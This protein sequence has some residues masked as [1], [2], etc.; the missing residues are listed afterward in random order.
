MSIAHTIVWKLT[1]DARAWFNGD[2]GDFYSKGLSVPVWVCV[3]AIKNGANQRIAI[4]RF[5]P[6][7]GLNALRQS[8]VLA[9]GIQLISALLFIGATRKSFKL[10]ITSKYFLIRFLANPSTGKRA[11]PRF[12]DH[13]LA[14]QPQ[15][16]CPALR[17]VC[18]LFLHY[19][20]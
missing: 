10:N 15:Y 20:W 18:V 4:E 9:V 14:K 16:R 1:Y 17:I 5:G 19:Y 7:E 11:L 3:I 13:S 8:W 6:Y 12:C 2:S